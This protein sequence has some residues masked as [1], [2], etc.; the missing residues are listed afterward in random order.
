VNKLICG[1]LAVA[2]C[3]ALAGVGVAETAQVRGQQ[4]DEGEEVRLQA[5]PPSESS[6]HH[7]WS[8]ERHPNPHVGK[9]ETKDLL[10]AKRPN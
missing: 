7:K 5:R 4:K 3:V 1:V 6:K 8:M 2:G 9:E 10:R